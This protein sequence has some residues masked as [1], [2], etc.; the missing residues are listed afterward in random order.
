MRPVY[1]GGEFLEHK[2]KHHCLKQSKG[3]GLLECVGFYIESFLIWLQLVW[4]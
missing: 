4:F 1:G 3:N 2:A